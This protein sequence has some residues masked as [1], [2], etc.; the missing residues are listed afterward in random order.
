MEIARH[1]ISPGWARGQAANPNTHSWMT[2]FPWNQCSF[3]HGL[4]SSGTGAGCHASQSF[5]CVRCIG[6]PEPGAG[7]Q[8]DIGCSILR[9]SVLSISQQLSLGQRKGKS[10][11]GENEAQATGAHCFQL[12]GNSHPSSKRSTAPRP[13][14]SDSDF[15]TC[16]GQGKLLLILMTK[17]RIVPYYLYKS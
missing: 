2:A 5:P 13:K 12:S 7:S 10:G 9:F 16:L 11:V 3:F 8:A 14:P 1:C 4:G 15:I 6:A 17:M